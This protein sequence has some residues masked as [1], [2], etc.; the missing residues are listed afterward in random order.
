[1]IVD[2]ERIDNLRE[3]LPQIKQTLSLADA[4]ETTSPTLFIDQAEK[5][6]LDN[7]QD[8]QERERIREL[9]N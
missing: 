2:G 5:D 1:M 4:I 8:A 6:L 9:L 7:I 3:I